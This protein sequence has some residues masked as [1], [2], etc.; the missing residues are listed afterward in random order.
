MRRG[1]DSKKNGYY[2][3]VCL[4]C[5]FPFLFRRSHHIRLV[6]QT[7]YSNNSLN[8]I[9]DKLCL[10]L[11][12]SSCPHS[13]LPILRNRIRD[14]PIQLVQRILNKLIA[15]FNIFRPTKPQNSQRTLVLLTRSRL[16]SQLRIKS[17]FS[18][19]FSPC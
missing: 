8:I 19:L 2:Q 14:V 11:P 17:T 1:T 7:R 12:K 3:A 6:S 15:H 13:L 18:I 4:P 9:Y 16:L 10:Y 5:G